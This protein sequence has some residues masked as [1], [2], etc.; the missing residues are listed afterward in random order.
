[1]KVKLHLLQRALTMKGG[2]GVQSV[3][4]LSATNFSNA[5]FALS[6]EYFLNLA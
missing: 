5:A 6:E 1:M 4:L 3:L 2:G